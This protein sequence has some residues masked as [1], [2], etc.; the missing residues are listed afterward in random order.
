MTRSHVRTLGVLILFAV[1]SGCGAAKT[2]PLFARSL[3]E[4]VPHNDRDHFVF[5]V[6]RPTPNGFRPA[7]LQVEHV[8]KLPEGNDYEVALSEDGMATGRVILR[9][10]GTTLW[11]VAE[12]DYTRGLRLS[13][14]PPLPYLSVPLFAGESRATSSADLRQL[15]TNQAAGRLPVVQVT[16]A[17]AEPAGQWFAGAYAGGVRLEVQRTYQSPDGPMQLSSTTILVPGIGEVRSEG[18]ASGSPV[19][20]RQLACATIGNRRIGDCRSLAERFR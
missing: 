6:E 10:D 4:L 2:Q 15:G 5:L 18:A 8:T 11:L 1:G 14:E 3:A 12:E 20:R 7:A 16:R 17:H 9:D 13:Y 19:M